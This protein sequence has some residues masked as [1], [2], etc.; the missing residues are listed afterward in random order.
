LREWVLR[1]A[2]EDHPGIT[3]MKDHFRTKDVEPRFW[4]LRFSSLGSTKMRKERDARV[5]RLVSAPN[6]PNSMKWRSLPMSLCHHWFYGTTTQFELFGI[7]ICYSGLLQPVQ[8]NQN[9][10]DH[11]CEILLK[12]WKKFFQ[13]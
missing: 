6:P 11:W 2:H 13:D 1:A 10:E 8:R 5:A 12:H 4:S 9:H 3:A 7:F